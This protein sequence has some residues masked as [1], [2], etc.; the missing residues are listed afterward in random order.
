[1]EGTLGGW[2]EGEVGEEAG[3]LQLAGA[4]GVRLLSGSKWDINIPFEKLRAV[5]KR[6]ATVD[7][8][9]LKKE[10]MKQEEVTTNP[11]PSLL[12]LDFRREVELSKALEKTMMENVTE[13]DLASLMDSI[14]IDACSVLY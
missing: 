2:R 11:N 12:E 1:M 4:G 8:G 3:K 5:E 7:L 10:R 13:P 6:I 14:E 9:S